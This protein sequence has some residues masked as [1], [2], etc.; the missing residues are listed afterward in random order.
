M[1]TSNRPIPAAFVAVVVLVL[2]GAAAMAG[3]VPSVP[4][5]SL[6]TGTALGGGG[7]AGTL[8]VDDVDAP[9]RIWTGDDLSVTVVVNNTGDQQ[10]TRDVRF[11]VDSDG[12][13]SREVAGERSVTVDAGATES[14]TFSLPTGDDGLAAGTHTYQVDTA[15]DQVDG[16]LTFSVLRPAH[17][18]VL[19]TV[20]QDPVVAGEPAT[21]TA[22]VENQGDFR[23]GRVVALAVD[24]DGDGTFATDEQV[25][26]ATVNVDPR[27][28]ETTSLALPTDRLTP[29]TYDYR[30]SVRDESLTGELTVVSPA[31]FE[32][33]NLSTP[34]DVVRGD[35]MTVSAVVTN[36]GD[37]AGT[38]TVRLDTNATGFVGVVSASNA[39]DT[40]TGATGN[41][42]GAT[43]SANGTDETATANESD[44]LARTVTLDS[45][46][47]TTVE[48]EV[49]TGNVTGG[50]YAV[51][52][53]SP[54]DTVTDRLQV[55]QPFFK[56]ARLVTPD[57]DDIGDRYTF[58]GIVQ[59]TGDANGTKLVDLR[60]DVDDDN[61]PESVGINRTV[62]VASGETA[63]VELEMQTGHVYPQD[64]PVEN[65]GKGTYIYGV[66]TE[67]HNRT[68]TVTFRNP[69]DGSDS[70][71]GGSSDS[72][73]N[74]FEVTKDEIAQTKYGVYY[75]SLSGETQA[76]V[77]EID[78]RQPFADG[79]TMA[80]VETREEIARRLGYY[81]G[82]YH[83]VFHEEITVEQQQIVEKQFDAQFQSEAGD[84]IESWEEL[85]QAEYD[86]SYDA[87][88]ETQQ[89]DIRDRYDDQF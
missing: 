86:T 2:V 31:A 46:E 48:F 23:A 37:V 33:S 32:L 7:T 3:A 62:T 65:L 84:R 43:E 24:I 15:D 36:T 52:V 56:V 82:D 88:N 18:S 67:D 34:A 5:F 21:M 81:D 11:L 58:V 83:F 49:A 45:G 27:A 75:V 14:I 47:S 70:S 50:T 66:Y 71:D 89:S 16:S 12:D 13:G 74:A 39:S 30:V 28:T 10:A 54:E 40:L 9:S 78:R 68:T 55:R 60:I 6:G 61:K 85:A 73:E 53:A 80:D 20:P 22:E 1:S 44:A 72:D 8:V 17:V 69:T 51:G 63:R 77:D 19:E 79:F 26:N 29:G 42:T 35:R 57:V 25:S 64:T 41:E 59:N 87:L 38:K 4:G 76:Q